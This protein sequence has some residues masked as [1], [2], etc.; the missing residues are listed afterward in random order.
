M[1]YFQNLVEQSLN[2]TREATL[3]MLGISDTGLR[4]HLANQISPELGAEGCFLAP[5]VFEHTFGWKQAPESLADLRDDLL[6]TTLLDTLSKAHA[7][8]FPANAHPYS[9]QLMA[10]KTLL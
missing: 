4:K 1:N 5:P 6:S 3:S 10:W 2:R 7:Y 9:H 8:K